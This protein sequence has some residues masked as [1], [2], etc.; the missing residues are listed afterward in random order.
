[1][2]YIVIGILLMTLAYFL[3]VAL[4]RRPRVKHRYL[5]EDERPSFHTIGQLYATEISEEEEFENTIKRSDEEE[6]SEVRDKENE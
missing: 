6:L 5:E 1:M 3:I 4:N 2:R